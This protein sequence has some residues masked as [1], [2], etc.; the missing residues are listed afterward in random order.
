MAVNVVGAW[1]R[2]N[3]SQLSF[4]PSDY[5]KLFLE[6]ILSENDGSLTL[7]EINI[8][9]DRGSLLADQPILTLV[10]KEATPA[11][12]QIVHRSLGQLKWPKD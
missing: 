6:T 11:S 10:P 8:A 5:F 1:F 2:K 7:E 9:A 4:E 12:L 3:T